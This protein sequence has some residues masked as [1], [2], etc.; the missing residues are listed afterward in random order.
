MQSIPESVQK[1]VDSINVELRKPPK[2]AQKRVRQDKANSICA[3]SE[4]VLTPIDTKA[5]R[6]MSVSC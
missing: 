3:G 1:V 4:M 6:R 5:E 2:A